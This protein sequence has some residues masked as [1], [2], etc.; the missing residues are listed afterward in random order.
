MTFRVGQ[1]VECIAAPVD[2]LQPGEVSAEIGGIYTIR[3]MMVWGGVLG[4][5]LEEIR[6]PPVHCIGG[7]HER[8]QWAG[9]FRP[10]VTRKTDIAFAHEI[11]RKASKTRETVG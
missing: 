11:L 3:G 10:L 5:L 8:H 9:R 4:L 7:F 1:K 2:D 6:N